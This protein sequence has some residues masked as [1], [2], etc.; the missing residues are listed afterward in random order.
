VGE[1]DNE[2]NQRNRQFLTILL[3]TAFAINSACSTTTQRLGPT[4]A[5][6][7]HNGVGKGD[8]VLIRYANEGDPRSTSRSEDVL[9]T[10]ISKAG[11]SGTG[12]AGRAITVS[13]DEIFEI[14]RQYRDPVINIESPAD[15]ADAVLWGVAYAA[16]GGAAAAICVEAP[17]QCLMLAAE[18]GN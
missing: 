2:M 13:Y 16:I 9:I 7:N 10:G 18:M 12:A 14:E 5:A 6:M 15:V 17:L 3:C 1:K 11:I 4:Q 8:M